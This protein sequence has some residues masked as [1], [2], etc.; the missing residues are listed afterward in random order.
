M[1]DTDWWHE[2]VPAWRASCSSEGILTHA[3]EQGYTV[4]Q[5][6]PRLEWCPHQKASQFSV[7]ADLQNSTKPLA[8]LA[9]FWL[10]K[11]APAPWKASVFDRKNRGP[12]ERFLEEPSEIEWGYWSVAHMGQLVEDEARRPARG[13]YVWAHF[14]TPHPSSVV[15]EHCAYRGRGWRGGDDEGGY[16]P[17]AVCALRLAGRLIEELQRL[18]RFEA[19]TIIIQADHGVGWAEPLSASNR[20]PPW[21]EARLAEEESNHQGRGREVNSRSLALLLIKRPGPAREPLRT[22]E[23]PVSLVDLP[24]TL[25]ALHG[26]PVRS[27][28]GRDF[29]APDF[30]AT[31]ER[32]LFIRLPGR[33]LRPGGKQDWHLVI[34]GAEWRVG[35]DYPARIR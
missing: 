2:A 16:R 25:Y 10:L 24:Q 7:G 13:Q 27:P 26:W 30:P 22:D 4:T 14:G 29:L 12:F 23:R 20:M 17:Q 8:G 21:L 9:D 15:D 1:S 3:W 18:Q 33:K 34:D 32:H 28:E 6:V 5:Y 35:A 19:A 11:L 31:R